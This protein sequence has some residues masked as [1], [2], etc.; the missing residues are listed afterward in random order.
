MWRAAVGCSAMTAVPFFLAGF[1]IALFGTRGALSESLGIAAMTA[2]MSFA[3]ALILFMVDSNRAFSDLERVRRRL[4]QR[5]D[6]SVDD[7]MATFETGDRELVEHIRSQLAQFFNVSTSKIRSDE[8]LN[9][10]SFNRFM[11]AIYLA[12]MSGLD[13]RAH[14]PG[15]LVSFPTRQ[16][17]TFSDL[18]EEGKAL[19]K[20]D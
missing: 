16:L 2:A 5:D 8:N 7:F 17:A 3:A 14:S 4:I 6:Q 13:R 10:L 20:T 18:I 12:V 1:V 9:A 19:S 11:P 15:K